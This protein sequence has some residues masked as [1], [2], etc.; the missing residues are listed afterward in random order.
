MKARLDRALASDV[1]NVIDW[2]MELCEGEL[3]SIDRRTIAELK[4]ELRDAAEPKLR[5]MSEMTEWEKQQYGELNSECV[6]HNDVESYA[7]LIDFFIERG[8]DYNGTLNR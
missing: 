4:D 1:C 3:T 2:L 5:P 6:A 8:L 7:Q